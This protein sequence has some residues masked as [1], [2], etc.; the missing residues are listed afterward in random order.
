MRKEKVGHLADFVREVSV[1]QAACRDKQAGEA[2]LHQAYQL[3]LA[4]RSFEN[5]V[6]KTAP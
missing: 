4:R 3:H 5:R 1:P 2:L 6:V